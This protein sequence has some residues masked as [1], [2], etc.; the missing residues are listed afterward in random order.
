MEES[1]VDLDTVASHLAWPDTALFMT[2]QSAWGLAELAKRAGKMGYVRSLLSERLL[3]CRGAKASGDIETYFKLDCPNYGE[4]SDELLARASGPL[5]GRRLLVSFCGVVDTELL[6][7]LRG[8]ASEVRYVQVYHTEEAPEANA[9]EAAGRFLES[10]HILVFTSGVG[11]EAFF[12][13]VEKAGLLR[14]V[15]EAANAGRSVIA[16]AQW[17]RKQ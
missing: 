10:R 12:K 16:V 8:L 1:G 7:Q 17:L 4:T 2:S 11:A 15:V 13:A 9:V 5:R 3:L 14:D 6:E